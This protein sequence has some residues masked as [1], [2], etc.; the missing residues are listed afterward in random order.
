MIDMFK[1]RIGRFNKACKYGVGGV[2]RLERQN[3]PKNYKFIYII[4]IFHCVDTHPSNE[5]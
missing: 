2:F 1:Y 3:A 4:S 5:C